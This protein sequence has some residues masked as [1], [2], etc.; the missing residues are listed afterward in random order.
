MRIFTVASAE[1]ISKPVSLVNM[2]RTEG[3]REQDSY[4]EGVVRPHTAEPK[5]QRANRSTEAGLSLDITLDFP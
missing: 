4:S 5:T 3:E 1:L 2:V